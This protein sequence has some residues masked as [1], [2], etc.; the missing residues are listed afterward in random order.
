MRTVRR[1]SCLVALVATVGLPG[2]AGAAW[3]EPTVVAVG[4][5]AGPR[6]APVLAA[7]DRGAVTAWIDTASDGIRHIMASSLALDG[8]A[9]PP[10][11]LSLPA[12]LVAADTDLAIAAN[13][14]G[15][16]AVAWR[17]TDLMVATR[18]ADGTWSVS[19]SGLAVAGSTIADGSVA[20]DADGGVIAVASLAAPGPGS[21]EMT[22]TLSTVVR[23]PGATA[24]DP[25][26]A[27]ETRV[28]VR[29]SFGPV[30]I[31]AGPIGEAA[32]SWWDRDRARVRVSLRKRSSSFGPAFD[33]SSSL[34]SLARSRGLAVATELSMSLDG[35]LAVAWPAPA[36]LP[37]RSGIGVRVIDPDGDMGPLLGDPSALAVD[38]RAKRRDAAL[39]GIELVGTEPVV[40]WLQR[41]RQRRRWTARVSTVDRLGAFA[42]PRGLAF[43]GTGAPSIRHGRRR[44][45]R[46]RLD[47]GHVRRPP[48]RGRVIH[49]FR[50][51]RLGRSRSRSG[52]SPGQGGVLA[53]HRDGPCQQLRL[54]HAPDRHWRHRR[55]GWLDRGA[56]GANGC[57]VRVAGNRHADLVPLGVAEWDRRV[58][59]L[60]PER[61]TAPR[62]GHRHHAGPGRRRQRRP[63]PASREAWRRSGGVHRLVAVPS[64][65]V[66][67]LVRGQAAT[68]ALRSLSQR[69]CRVRL[70]STRACA[71]RRSARCRAP[72]PFGRTGRPSPSSSGVDC[73]ALCRRHRRGSG[74]A[75][76]RASP[77][78]CRSGRRRPRAG[79][80]RKRVVRAEH[81]R[82]RDAVPGPALDRAQG[83][84]ASGV[85]RVRE[86]GWPR[87]PSLRLPPPSVRRG[88]APAL[89]AERRAAAEPWC[90]RRADRQPRR[91]PPPLSRPRPRRSGRRTVRRLRRLRRSAPVLRDP[92]RSRS[93]RGRTDSDRGE[94]R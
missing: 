57:V 81:R 83:V 44:P 54:R 21:A 63:L 51:R 53:F 69:G 86:V 47:A 7:Y 43:C 48:G 39:A 66:V 80:D 9:T 89:R 10:V 58:H 34:P 49:T 52:R 29:R 61:K 59:P 41:F 74:R 37:R 55:F 28:A 70:E 13:R 60:D 88:H 26:Q 75:L 30:A 77:R 38:A 27:V 20:V 33:V 90:A 85:R 82:R 87:V 50:R 79:A 1:L 14:A 92:R 18:A 32:L 64:R 25:P 72:A 84:R 40:A 35:T 16:V 67:P 91:D 22:S 73:D 31:A 3:L 93:R 23:S 46:R 78:R 42:T 11:E 36:V 76:V 62:S 68:A 65:C 2:A 6:S 19:A 17:E 94:T 4:G 24:F 45:C 5:A 71:A 8:S 12:N 15:V 56:R